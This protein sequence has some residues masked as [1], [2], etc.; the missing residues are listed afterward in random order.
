MPCKELRAA[1]VDPMDLAIEVE[2]ED[3]TDDSQFESAGET[4]ADSVLPD[5]ICFQFKCEPKDL[6]AVSD[7]LIKRSFSVS[8]ASLEYVPK[9][10]VPLGQ[11]E[12][13]RA[14]RV[15]NLLGD[16]DEVVEVYD[17]FTL[18]GNG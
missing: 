11:R 3:V 1:S 8:S 5:E 16:V 9:M 14:V 13:N 4:H 15:V 12:Y 17:N 10:L 2:A 18:S 7:A 6:K